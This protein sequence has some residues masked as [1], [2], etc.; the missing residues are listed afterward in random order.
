MGYVTGQPFQEPVDGIRTAFTATQQ[1]ETDSIQVFQGN[2]PLGPEAYREL[3]TVQVR[4]LD[5]A[6]HK[7]W[8]YDTTLNTLYCESH[9][10]NEG[11]QVVLWSTSENGLPE[12]LSPSLVY[13]LLDV[14]ENR[15]QV[16]LT[17]GGDPVEFS[18][19][20]AGILYLALP[21]A[22]LP[23]NGNLWYNATTRGDTVDPSLVVG[24]WVL[25]DWQR[26]YAS[27]TSLST[28]QDVLKDAEEAVQEYV[29]ESSYGQAEAQEKPY[30]RLFRRVIGELAFFYLMKRPGGL[31][32]VK[33]STK[34]YG[35][36]T[37]KMSQQYDTSVSKLMETSE[38]DILSQLITYKKPSADTEEAAT[39]PGALTRSWG[40]GRNFGFVGNQGWT[41]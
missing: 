13:F 36:S 39:T 35:D 40:T 7:I 33:S 41:I 15:F 24:F 34:Q 17:Q 11:T 38:K 30:Y 25:A 37:K 29:T 27:L 12:G 9:G 32:Q 14:D 22:P 16:S 20:A 26:Q 8:S 5:P 19:S 31:Q 18:Q 23:E 2:L 6:S 1:F 10:L 4:I 3:S 28:V 21:E